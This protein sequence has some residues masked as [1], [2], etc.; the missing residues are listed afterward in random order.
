VRF[1]HALTGP[2]LLVIALPVFGGQVV[3]RGPAGPE[4]CATH[5]VCFWSKPD[6]E[7]LPQFDDAEPSADCASMDNVSS[8]WFR[9]GASGELLELWRG[10]DCQGTPEV[11]LQPGGKQDNFPVG[12]YKLEAK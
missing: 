7:G 12:S 6:F 4:Q 2:A 5:K 3:G 9:D 10:P 1:A 11:S 8:V